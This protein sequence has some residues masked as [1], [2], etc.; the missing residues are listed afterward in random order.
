MLNIRESTLADGYILSELSMMIINKMDLPF[1]KEVGLENLRSLIEQCFTDPK[2]RNDYMQAA[3]GEFDGEVVGAAF[4]FTS[5]QEGKIDEIFDKLLYENFGVRQGFETKEAVGDEWYL[6]TIAVFE[7]MRGKGIG[8]KLLKYLPKIAKKYD[9]D[10]IGLNVADTNL[11]AKKLYLSHNFVET[12]KELLGNQRF[13][14]M[15]WYF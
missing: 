7:R 5:E 9:K 4:G 12:G 13:T 8:T 2:Y 10:C 1:I 14:H 11:T 15:R 6:D 3:V